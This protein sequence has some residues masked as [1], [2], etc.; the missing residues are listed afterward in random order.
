MCQSRDSPDIRRPNTWKT[1]WCSREK[2][3]TGRRI[4]DPGSAPKP[5]GP[6]AAR[7]DRVLT[8]GAA[9]TFTNTSVRRCPVTR[10]L[11]ASHPAALSLGLV[12][13]V[14]GIDLCLPLGVAS[15]VPYTFAVLLALTAK[16]GWLGPAVAAVC[17]VLT[18]A[19][20]G[21]V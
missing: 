3:V 18:V 17:M 1:T 7:P 6:R 10:R 4:R 20:M 9:T 8:T 12:A 19:K 15:A 13:T 5:P 21:I 11:L 16:P 2:M 14:F